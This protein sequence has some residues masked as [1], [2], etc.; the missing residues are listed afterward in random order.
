MSVNK[1]VTIRHVIRH[2]LRECGTRSDFILVPWFRMFPEWI[3]LSG[4]GGGGRDAIL[5][6]RLFHL[7]RYNLTNDLSTRF[8]KTTPVY[9]YYDVFD[10]QQ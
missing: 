2:C 6:L 3:S 1:R 9:R 5:P 4:G 10:P 8:E 7:R